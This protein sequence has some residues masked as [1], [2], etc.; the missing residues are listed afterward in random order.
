MLIFFLH[1]IVDI[2]IFTHL[3][4]VD[5]ES[6]RFKAASDKWRRLFTIPE[7]EKLVNCKYNLNDF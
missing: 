7:E 6:K 1:V 3:L 5:E 4:Y 2:L